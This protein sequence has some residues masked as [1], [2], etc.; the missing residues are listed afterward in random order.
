MASKERPGFLP[1]LRA[2]LRL[3]RIEHALLSAFGVLVGL[4][5]ASRLPNSCAVKTIIAIP[6][7]SFTAAAFTLTF[8]LLVP[9]LI[10]VG[11][12]ALNDYWDVEADRLNKRKERPLVSGELSPAIALATGIAGIVLGVLAGALI[13]SEAGFIALLFALLSVAY[14]KFLKD[15]PLAGNLS[16]ALS[17]AIAFLFG[18]VAAGVPLACTGMA[19][20]I[21]CAGAALGGFG[22]ELVKTVQDM[23]GDKEAR[24]SRSLPHVIGKLSSL[25]LAA[26]SFVLYSVSVPMLVLASPILHWNP[27][28]LGLLA[29]SVL[30]F[31]AMAWQV[32]RPKAGAD[33][34]ERVRS[35]SLYALA[36]ALL[37]VLLACA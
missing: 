11:A 7:L 15:W 2:W 1:A 34:L 6:A 29:I 30:A 37:A 22:R 12:F 5:L 3:V 16:I 21:L 10:N 33:I 26:A 4:M 32:V 27:L 31:I 24:G 9:V 18:S 36:L 35:S 28:S 19:V 17:M 20:W 25:R 13:N 14:S 23:E 8:A